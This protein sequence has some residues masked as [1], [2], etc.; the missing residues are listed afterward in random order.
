VEQLE[1]ENKE[2]R[3]R[4]D[5]LETISVERLILAATTKKRHVVMKHKQEQ[6]SLS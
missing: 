6:E 1:E 2:L 4:L 5:R 3:A